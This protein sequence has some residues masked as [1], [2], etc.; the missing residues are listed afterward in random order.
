MWALVAVASPAGRGA[1]VALA[2]AAK[3]APL[4][5]APLFARGAS[6]M[7]PGP[8]APGGRWRRGWRG[9]FVYALVFALVTAAVF[10]PFIP[11]GGLREI[12][13][14]TI[15]YQAGRASPFSVWGQ[16]GGLG[17]LHVAVEAAAVALAL[18]V[19]VVPRRRTPVQVAAL[20]LAVTVA[21]Q[22]TV[23]HWFYL[24]VVWFAPFLLVAVFARYRGRH[25]AGS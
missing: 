12:F 2:G 20:A 5:L 4:A 9:V 10:L 8:R 14:R 19:A 1:F 22:L 24:Y 13:D 15:G 11:D 23:N 18:V 6:P 17:W 7:D 16:F 21:I 25:A 3:F